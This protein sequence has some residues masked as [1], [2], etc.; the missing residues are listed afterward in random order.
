MDELH[1]CICGPDKKGGAAKGVELFKIPLNVVAAHLTKE[2][3]VVARKRR[4]EWLKL[5][6]ENVKQYPVGKVST[7]ICSQ[8]FHSGELLL[9]YFY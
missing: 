8:H 9:F 6:R 5:L 4:D 2:E 1:C 7:Y 3:K